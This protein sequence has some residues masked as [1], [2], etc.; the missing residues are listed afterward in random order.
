MRTR[1]RKAANKLLSASRSAP[2]PQHAKRWLSSTLTNTSTFL[3]G[4][5]PISWTT[6]QRSKQSVGGPAQ[7]SLLAPPQG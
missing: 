2:N 1:T 5:L 4:S 6:S 3:Q 7:L